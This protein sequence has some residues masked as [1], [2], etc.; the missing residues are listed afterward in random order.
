MEGTPPERARQTV[1]KVSFVTTGMSPGIRKKGAARRERRRA[2]LDGGEHIRRGKV[3]VV[4]GN[5]GP[6]E[7]AAAQDCFDLSAAVAKHDDDRADAAQEHGIDRIFNDRLAAQR[8]KGLEAAHPAGK[9]GG[10][11]QSADAFFHNCVLRFCQSAELCSFVGMSVRFPLQNGISS[12]KRTVQPSC[13]SA[14]REKVTTP[15]ISTVSVL[16]ESAAR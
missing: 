2:E 8:Q 9:P 15:R 16:P 1:R 5:D 3:A 4:H 10:D 6:G 7:V 14:S 13:A 11:D 12:T